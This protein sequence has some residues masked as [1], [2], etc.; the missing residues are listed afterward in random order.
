M[1]ETRQQILTILKEKGQ[2]TVEALAGALA[3]TP[4]TVRH[5]LSIL[6]GE[7]YLTAQQVRRKVG[8][9]HY[10]YTLTDKASDLFPQGYHL[11]TERLLDEIK[12]MVGPDGTNVLL[13][14]LAD[15][16]A[17]S[18]GPQLGNGSLEERLDQAARL[19]VAEGFLARWEKA[20]DGYIF[21]ELNCPYRRVI[22]RHPEV[23]AMDQR[24]LSEVLRISVEKIDCIVVGGERCAY[25][26]QTVPQTRQLTTTTA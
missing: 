7:G 16:L 9:P 18:I 21:Y 2:A 12:T 15:K 22:K 1:Q 11:L 4:I 17:A 26:V 25:R 3:L 10:V 24:F 20:A 23:C 13:T 14:R 8:R 5:H 6:L 19:L